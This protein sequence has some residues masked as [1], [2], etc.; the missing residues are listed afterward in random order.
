MSLQISETTEGASRAR[1]VV[2]FVLVDSV[3]SVAEDVADDSV[4][5]FGGRLGG[6]FEGCSSVCWRIGYSWCSDGMRVA[7]ICLDLGR[8]DP[9]R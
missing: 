1:R 6:G 2:A 5:R 9:K 4:G 3:D 7:M 8:G